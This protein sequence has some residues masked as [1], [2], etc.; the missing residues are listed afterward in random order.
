MK[1]QLFLL[2]LF[3]FSQIGVFSQDP[4]EK[5]GYKPRIHTLSNEKYQE[6][7]DNEDVVRIGTALFN[8]QTNKIVGY[9]EDDS[10]MSQK[11]ETELASRW[12]SLDPMAEEYPSW[13]PYNYAVNNPI[14]NYDP[15]GKWVES[16]LDIGFI[17]Y[18]LGEMA[19]DYAKTGSVNSVSVAALGADVACLIAPVATGGGLAVRA[20]REGGEQVAKQVTKGVVKEGAEKVMK[21]TA[22]KAPKAIGP[23]GD[24]G[25]KVMKQLPDDMQKNMRTTDNKQGTIFKDPKN[26]GGNNVRVQGGNPKSPNSAQQKPYVKQVKD[27]KTVDV[28]GK[29]VKPDSP[30]SH[31]P[32][33]EFRY[34]K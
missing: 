28:N 12:L 8:T 9:V 7:F 27:G 13:S 29:Q 24:A 14:N 2:A 32:K 34:N 20:A 25:G 6:F 10:A 1:K 22:E 30:E 15:N 16:F 19:Y 3:L 5:Y 21:E 33:D 11:L 31:I 23:A 4:F 17:L 26:P 18:D